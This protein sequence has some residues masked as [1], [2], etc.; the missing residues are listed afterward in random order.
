M[1]EKIRSSGL[2]RAEVFVLLAIAIVLPLGEFFAM[3]IVA[4]RVGDRK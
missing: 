4:Y 1:L 3:A 2:S